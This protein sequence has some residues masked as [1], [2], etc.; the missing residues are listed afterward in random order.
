M[1]LGCAKPPCSRSTSE[2]PRCTRPR[3]CPIQTQ[4]SNR[5]RPTARPDSDATWGHSCQQGLGRGLHGQRQAPAS[6]APKAP[7]TLKSF[8]TDMKRGDRLTFTHAGARHSGERRWDGEGN[9][10]RRRLRSSVLVYLVGAHPPN[11]GLKAGLR[12]APAHEAKHLPKAAGSL[13]AGPRRRAPSGASDPCRSQDRPRRPRSERHY[14]GVPSLATRIR[15]LRARPLR[16][17]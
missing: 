17:V 14:H 13:R 11:P 6:G 15:A 3:P 1:V 7:E 5:A 12:A 9:D 4:S 16:P 2:W 8:M 10:R